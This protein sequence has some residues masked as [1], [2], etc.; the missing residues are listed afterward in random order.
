QSN[1]YA[2]PVALLVDAGTASV[3]EAFAGCLQVHGR[4]V[5]V[6]ERTHG[7]G[8]VQAVVVGPDGKSRYATVA[9]IVLPGGARLQ[10]VG[11]QPDLP[12]PR[13]PD[14]ASWRASAGSL[15]REL[16]HAVCESFPSNQPE[17]TRP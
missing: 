14:V 3:A 13:R 1:D 5:V 11:V 15:P 17:R 12:A 6:G 16:Q 8:D 2:F 7:K 10:G 9:T 4:A